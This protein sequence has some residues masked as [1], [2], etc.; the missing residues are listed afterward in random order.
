MRDNFKHYLNL[1]NYLLSH[2][3]EEKMHEEMLNMLK[4]L[5][6]EERLPSLADLDRLCKAAE[7]LQCCC[8]MLVRQKILKEVQS[9]LTQ[10]Y[11]G[12]VVLRRMDDGRAQDIGS[13]E[14]AITAKWLSVGVRMS[15]TIVTA[16][17][18]SQEGS[19][20]DKEINCDR[21]GARKDYKVEKFL[22]ARFPTAD[23]CVV[24]SGDSCAYVR[25]ICPPIKYEWD[26]V[27]DNADTL[28]KEVV[29]QFDKMRVTF[30]QFDGK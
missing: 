5:A 6:R 29:E 19:A 24:S 23:N 21:V 11:P 2:Q 10:R 20:G 3:Q 26:D 7:E 16:L 13:L 12:E 30:Q 8:G 28:A 22:T 9:L 17:W 1:I 18:L 14:V 25:N 15:T 27:R 4:L